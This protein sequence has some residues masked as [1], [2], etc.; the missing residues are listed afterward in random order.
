I[1]IG[2]PL[3]QLAQL[4]KGL[5]LINP[6]AGFPTTC[7]DGYL[8]DKSS[9]FTKNAPISSVPPVGG[10]ITHVNEVGIVKGVVIVFAGTTIGSLIKF[11]QMAG[12]N[13]A[14]LVH[15]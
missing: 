15:I 7:D 6:Q 3:L 8:Q 4:P 2:M 14:S 11:V 10:P 5:G 12:G 1:V 13:D 9:K